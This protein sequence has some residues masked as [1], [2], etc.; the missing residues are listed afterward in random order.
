LRVPPATASDVAISRLKACTTEIF[1]RFGNR[2]GTA[3]L[4]MTSL[5]SCEAVRRLRT[6]LMRITG[7]RTSRKDPQQRGEQQ[8]KPWESSQGREFF[9]DTA[10]PGHETRHV[11][12]NGIALTGGKV[13][14]W[15]L[16]MSRLPLRSSP[17]FDAIAEGAQFR[18]R[19]AIVVHTPPAAIFEALQEVTLPEMKVAW[20]LGEI[21]YLPSRLTGR[22]V[23]VNPRRPFLSLLREGGTIV[24]RDASP[25]EVITGSAGRLHQVHQAPMRFDSREA[26]DAFHDPAYEKLFISIRVAPTGV[27]G[28]YWL[29]LEHATRALSP[30]TER[31]FRRY[32]RL[33]KPAGAFVSRELLHAIR[34][35]A[36]RATVLTPAKTA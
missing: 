3:A 36:R 31:K 7:R 28:E 1:R 33:I 25:R 13:H 30:D 21:R 22:L 15:S 12:R 10:G 19:V 17:E 14:A 9:S 34:N 6:P 32:W 11:F 27:I 18:D 26:F 5:L 8:G 2:L 29:V 4:T 24:L 16:S 35:R 20:L 23:A